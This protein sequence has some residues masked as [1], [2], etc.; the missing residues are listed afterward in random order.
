[1]SFWGLMAGIHTCAQPACS[2]SC[3]VAN[4]LSNILINLIKLN[5]MEWKYTNA[6]VVPRKRRK[7]WKRGIM[8][9][10][11]LIAIASTFS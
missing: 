11:I 1:M 5:V 9:G 10:I 3:S 8:L 6:L 2:Y 4:V 7:S